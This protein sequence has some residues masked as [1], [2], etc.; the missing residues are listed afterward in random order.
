[1][2]LGSRRKFDLPLVVVDTETTGLDA[3]EYDPIQ[4]GVVMLDE[5]LDEIDSFESLLRPHSSARSPRAMEV[6]KISEAELKNAPSFKEA[7]WKLDGKL[8]A[9]G[10]PLHGK[11]MDRTMFAAWNGSFDEQFVKEGCRKAEISYPFGFPVDVKTLAVFNFAKRGFTFNPGHGGGVE[12]ALQ[13]LGL[14][15]EGSAHNALADARNTARILK[16]FWEAK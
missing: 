3:R 14:E 8:R 4:I 16:T 6:N 7:I 15:F 2:K 11:Y 10:F 5:N 9:L 13:L 12:R 1:M